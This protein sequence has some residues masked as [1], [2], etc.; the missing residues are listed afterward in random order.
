MEKEI[1]L[2]YLS[3]SGY[4]FTFYTDGTYNKVIND[5]KEHKT[6]YDQDSEWRIDREFLMY[7]HTDDKVFYKWGTNSNNIVQELI[8]AMAIRNMINSD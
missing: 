6:Y 4:V 5:S 1:L 7:R 2:V 8:T 3:I